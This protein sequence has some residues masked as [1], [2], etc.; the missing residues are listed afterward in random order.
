MDAERLRKGLERAAERRAKADRLKAD[1]T[2]EAAALLRQV[3][4]TEGISMIEAAQ[5]LGVTR[6]MAYKLLEAGS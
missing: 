4:D 5:Q 6:A 1:A 2:A 3:A